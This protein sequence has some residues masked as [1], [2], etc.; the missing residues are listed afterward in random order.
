MSVQHSVINCGKRPTF[1]LVGAYLPVSPFSCLSNYLFV[2]L[3]LSPPQS[4]FLIACLSVCIL[5]YSLW[6]SPFSPPLSLS[7]YLSPLS[8][9]L[10]LSPSIPP[11]LSLPLF[12]LLSISFVSLTSLSLSFS[13]I[14]FDCFLSL[15]YF[16]HLFLSLPLSPISFY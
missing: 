6:L 2:F 8:F 12:L 3:N 5:L 16:F 7:L 11:P 10:Y 9:P 13:P 4:T 15:F 1:S 14:S